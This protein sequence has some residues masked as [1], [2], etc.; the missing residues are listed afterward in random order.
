MN[1][2]YNY[3]IVD[4]NGKVLEDVNFDDYDTLADHMLELADK[5]YKG[6]YTEDDKLKISAFDQ[7]GEMI[8]SDT[9]SFGESSYAVPDDFSITPEG[10][11]VN[12]R[13][14]GLGEEID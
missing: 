3:T 2:Y 5:W 6:E 7:T 1:E 14:E 11:P 13:P 8:Y 4:K 12:W 10:I 9:A